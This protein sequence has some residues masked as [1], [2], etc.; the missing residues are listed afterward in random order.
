MTSNRN[1][2]YGLW[3]SS[4][5]SLHTSENGGKEIIG[6]YF[7]TDDAV[8]CDHLC[9]E[10]PSCYIFTFHTKNG[11]QCALWTLSEA[12][13]QDRASADSWVAESGAT[14]GI[15]FEGSGNLFLTFIFSKEN[16]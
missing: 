12:I 4:T 6:Q 16:D 3:P 8:T 13:S 2:I 7:D 9:F 10:T 14:S 1:A 5:W 11:G 15:C